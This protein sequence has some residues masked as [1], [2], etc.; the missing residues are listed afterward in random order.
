MPAVLHGTPTQALQRDG[1][2]VPAPG[3]GPQKV[4]GCLPC[5]METQHKPWS[6]MARNVASSRNRAPTGD[7]VT[8]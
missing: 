8:V 5:C 3:M 4:T 1:K 6:G 7:Q 2:N